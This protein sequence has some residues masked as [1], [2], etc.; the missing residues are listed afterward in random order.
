[1]IRLAVVSRSISKNQIRFFRSSS[2]APLSSTAPAASL[3]SQQSSTAGRPLGEASTSSSSSQNTLWLASGVLASM[4]GLTIASNKN[5]SGI[6]SCEEEPEEADPYDNL[7]EEDEPT[8]CSICKTYRQGPCRPYWRKV[9]ACTK[10]NELGDSSKEK[11]ESSESSSASSDT[12]ANEED[13]TK[14][15]PCLKYMMPWI[16]CA[17]GYRNLYNWIEM[18]TNYTLGIADLEEEAGTSMCWKPGNEPVIDWTEWQTYVQEN[19]WKPPSKEMRKQT[20]KDAKNQ[21]PLWKTLDISEGDPETVSVTALVS[22][23][24]MDMPDNL[25]ECAYAQDQNGQV[26]GFAYGQKSGTE[27]KEGED[28][29]PYVALTI[30]LLPSKTTHVVLAASYLPPAEKSEGDDKQEPPKSRLYKSKPYKLK[31]VGRPEAKEAR[32][33]QVK[34]KQS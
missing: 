21:I 18:D 15:P 8:H 25:L 32:K 17:T 29:E 10:D 16:E 31:N 20:R 24:E 2:V 19:D 22:T 4:A 14:D 7:P 9:E 27:R 34:E 23:E 1:M 3:A 30:R 13:K 11:E 6:A 28:E 12:E 26:I 33:D 5:S